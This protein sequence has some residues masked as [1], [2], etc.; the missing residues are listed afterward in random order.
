[1][2]FRKKKSDNVMLV[3]VTMTV[4]AAGSGTRADLATQAHK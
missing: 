4:G 3:M 1:M 2:Q